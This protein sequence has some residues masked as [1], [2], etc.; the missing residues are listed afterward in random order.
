M[1]GAV[2]EELLVKGNTIAGKLILCLAHCSSLSLFL[3]YSSSM[4][5]H[6]PSVDI[7]PGGGD[8]LVMKAGSRYSSGKHF[9]SYHL[10][11]DASLAFYI[12]GALNIILFLKRQNTCL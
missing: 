9:T 5:D 1:V 2:S 4:L 7:N 10:L 12:K 11:V 6:F 8:F 3:N